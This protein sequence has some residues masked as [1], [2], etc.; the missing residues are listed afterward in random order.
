MLKRLEVFLIAAVFILMSA[1]ILII[2]S[3]QREQEF[4]THNTLIQTASVTGAAYAL[5]LQ[6]ANKKRHVRLFSEEYESLLNHLVI[7]PQDTKTEGDIKKRLHQRFPD[8]FT[9]TITDQTAVPKLFDIDSF[10][11]EACQHDLSNYIKKIKN[12]S[13]KTKLHNKIFIHPLSEHYHYDI[14]SSFGNTK[15]II[16]VFFVSFYLKEIVDILKTHETPGNQLFLLRQ[17]DPSLIEISSR[18]VRDKISR[19]IRLSKNEQ[20]RIQI[21]KNISGTDWHIANLPNNTY[22]KKYRL[23]LWKEA[24]LILLIETL[25]I[26]LLIYVLFKLAKKKRH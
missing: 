5:I 18:G 10:V 9:Y 14:M 11:G 3:K 6:L 1:V 26:L 25:S 17:S 24:G 4:K 16:N 21:V 20:Q 15:N 7:F 22:E 2:Y 19:D 13:D 12:V 23:G 8:F